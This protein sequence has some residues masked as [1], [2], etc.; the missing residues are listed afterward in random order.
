M[1]KPRLDLLFPVFVGCERIEACFYLLREVVKLDVELQDSYRP[2]QVSV[3]VFL[4]K[5]HKLVAKFVSESVGSHFYLLSCFNEF[6]FSVYFDHVAFWH[7]GSLPHF[8]FY[9]LIHSFEQHFCLTITTPRNMIEVIMNVAITQTCTADNEVFCSAWEYSGSIH[10][11]QVSI[12][13]LEAMGLITLWIV[14]CVSIVALI[15]KFS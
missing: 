3:V 11:I 5:D 4:G 1:F 15:R 8:Q 9:I 13:M 7:H 2:L 10:D 6:L 14:V 12:P